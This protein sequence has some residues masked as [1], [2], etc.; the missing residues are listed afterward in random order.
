MKH[1][2]TADQIAQYQEDGFTIVE[3]FLSPSE[4]EEWRDALREAVERRGNYTLPQQVD[5]F[6]NE[7][8]RGEEEKTV[9]SGGDDAT[10]YYSSVFVQR[11][12]L[13]MDNPRMKELILA[14]EIGKM[15]C[16]LEGIDAIRVWH[17]QTLMKAPWANPTAWHLDN[18][19]WS[20][21]ST[22]AISIWVALDDATPENGCLYFIPG[23]HKKQSYE[24][25]GIGHTM[26][27]LFKVHPDWA[28]QPSACAAMKAG[29]CSFHNGLTAHGAGANMT[30][31]WRRAMTC[32]FMPDG[33]TFNGQQN[34]LSREQFKKLTVG[35]VMNDDAQ[36]PIV[37]SRANGK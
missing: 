30:N 29:S 35:E 13:W 8:A 2:L 32:A 19:Y 16:E 37:Y 23:S 12:N 24:N 11:V 26:D 27:A 18:P 31:G 9:G 6:M 21:H 20:F 34:I 15:A 17:D 14:P 33:S 1:E 25:V 7:R 10:G 5:N 22:H 28:A 36:N 3:D 4:L